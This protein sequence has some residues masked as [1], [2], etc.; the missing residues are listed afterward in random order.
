[1]LSWIAA[2]LLPPWTGLEHLPPPSF[3]VPTTQIQPPFRPNDPMQLDST[4][5]TGAS[6]NLRRHQ[7]SWSSWIEPTLEYPMSSSPYFGQG[8]A[9]A[10]RIPAVE[11]NLIH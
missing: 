6:W 5:G 9:V 3:L 11:L 7:S 2:T 4:C 1:M 10:V 8:T